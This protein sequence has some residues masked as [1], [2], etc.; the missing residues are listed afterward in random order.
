M[1]EMKNKLIRE[2]MFEEDYISTKNFISEASDNKI[3]KSKSIEENTDFEYRYSNDN[4]YFKSEI[5]LWKAVILQALV[6]LQS[7]S[8]KKIANTYRIKALMWFNLKNEEFLTVCNYAGLFYFIKLSTYS[9]ASSIFLSV[10]SIKMASSAFLNGLATLFISCS[11]LFLIF[12]SI[13]S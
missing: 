1:V 6:D 2:L 13:S 8:K 12:S 3:Y 10:V 7:N 11:S 4:L 9:K 5:A